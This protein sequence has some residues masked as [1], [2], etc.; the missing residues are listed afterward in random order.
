MPR[1]MRHRLQYP[2]IANLNFIGEAAGQRESMA[3]TAWK[4]RTG[5]IMEVTRWGR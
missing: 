1:L 5:H 3:I 4:V 2:W